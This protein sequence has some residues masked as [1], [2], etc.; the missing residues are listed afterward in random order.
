[1]LSAAPSPFARLDALPREARDTLFLLLVIGWV[2][3][4]QVANLPVWCSVLAAGVLLWRGWLAVNSRPLPG[5]WWLAALLVIAV[6]GTFMTHRTVLGRD[7]GVTM[8]VVLLALKT[9]ELRAR[10]DAFVIFFLGFFTMLTN[11]FFSQS[12]LTA[13]AMLVA[14]LGLLTALVNAHMP[15]GRPPLAQAARTAGTMALLGAPIMAV[16]FVLFP[17]LA[18]LWGIPSDAM[19]GRSGLSATMQVGNLAS[20]ALDETIA[21]RV[22][23]Q[24]PT[25]Q[26]SDLYFRGPVLSSFDG[27]EWRALQPRLGS[28]ASTVLAGNARLEVAGTPVRYEV[29]MEPSNRPWLMVMDAAVNPPVTPGFASVMTSELQWVAS[30]PITD[31][32]RYSAESYPVFRHG[33]QVSAV[34]LPPQYTELPPGFNPRTL[35]LAAQMRQDPALSGAGN[36]AL[37]QAAINRLRTG[38]Y[39]YTLDPGVYGADTADEFWFDRKEGFCE[40]IASAFA[41]LMRAMDIPARVVTGYQGGERNSVDGFWV[42]RQSDAHAWTEVWLAGRGW[43]RVDPTSAVAPGRTGS[44]QRLQPPRGALATAF[45]NVTPELAINFRAAWDALNNSWNQWVLNYT[46]SK[47]LDMLKNLGFESPSWED[48][49][50]VLIALVVATALVGAAWTLW[51]RRQHDPWLRLLARTRRRLHEAGLDIPP[52][53][54]PRQIATLVTARFGTSAQAVADWLLAL[55]MQRYAR[56][57]Q[58]G[59]AALQRQFKQLAWPR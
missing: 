12:L 32:V 3:L 44:F 59:L 53:A 46:Q 17:R 28:F 21:M 10:R 39:R 14:L 58:A 26:Q 34:A 13:A 42:L 19:S 41:V 43:V 2:V 25:P 54:P 4:P 31:L 47:Q 40:H 35:A 30:R 22:K 24:G 8:L 37:V 45:G 11:F 49:S 57:P 29:T 36:A 56:T 38:G 52:T 7:A 5:K 48:L 55:E 50:Y 15:V 9:L 23:F 33:P 16:L 51:D 18:P 27:R 1:M 6:A 20:L